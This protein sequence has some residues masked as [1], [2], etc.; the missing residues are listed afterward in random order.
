[1]ADGRY[2]GTCWVTR[3]PEQGFSMSIMHEHYWSASYK[4]KF[5]YAALC[6]NLAFIT[7]YLANAYFL[8]GFGLDVPATRR[9]FSSFPWFRCL[10]T[11]YH[12]TQ[13][14]SFCNFYHTCNHLFNICVTYWTVK[15]ISFPQDMCHRCLIHHFIPNNEHRAQYTVGTQ[16]VFAEWINTMKRSGAMWNSVLLPF[17]ST[18]NLRMW[19]H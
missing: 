10:L 1:M 8:I 14:L 9:P 12:H 6:S 15:T 13:S 3:G 5:S 2:W 19:P 7:I 11:W 16:E 4:C 17:M 18:W